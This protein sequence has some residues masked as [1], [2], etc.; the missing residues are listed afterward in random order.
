MAFTMSVFRRI[1]HA[2]TCQECTAS[3]VQSS[4]LPSNISLHWQHLGEYCTVIR[5]ATDVT[6]ILYEKK[7]QQ[8]MYCNILLVILLI[9]NGNFST[10]PIP[11]QLAA[12]L[13]RPPSTFEVSVRSNPSTCT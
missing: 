7:T 5:Y 4:H 10:L 12:L 11:D 6:A 13:P 8:L 9:N 3:I 1:L 2:V